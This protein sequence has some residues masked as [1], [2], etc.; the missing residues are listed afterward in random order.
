MFGEILV[1]FIFNMV[2]EFLGDPLIIELYK[3]SSILQI[4]SAHKIV[5]DILI[6]IKA[7]HIELATCTEIIFST[8]VGFITTWATMRKH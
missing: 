3:G 4:D 1:A 5:I 7:R 8:N 2:K 6:T